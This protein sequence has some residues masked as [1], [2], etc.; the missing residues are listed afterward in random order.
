MFLEEIFYIY[1]N[2]ELKNIKQK[3]LVLLVHLVLRFFRIWQMINLA[4]GG[5]IKR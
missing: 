5:E 1:K 4:T 2:K 3:I